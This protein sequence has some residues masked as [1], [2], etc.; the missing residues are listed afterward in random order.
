MFPDQVMLPDTPQEGVVSCGLPVPAMEG[1]EIQ[2]DSVFLQH[3]PHP[4]LGNSRRS[5]LS[6]SDP[7]LSLHIQTANSWHLK[8]V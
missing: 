8:K 1:S 4:N 7:M 5:M 6:I 3:F 2:S